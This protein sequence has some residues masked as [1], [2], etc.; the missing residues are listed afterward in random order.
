M[1]SQ[2]KINIPEETS[3]H[4]LSHFESI[5]EIEKDRLIKSG[6]TSIQIEEQLS[7]PGSK[8]FK[9]FATSAQT[10]ID[11]LKTLCPETFTQSVPEQ[12]GRIRMS[13]RLGENI[14]R[15]G[16]IE[17]SSLSISERNTIREEE[18]N[19]VIIKTVR[20]DRI[21]YTNEC[22]LVLWTNNGHYGLCSIFPG[23]LAPPLPT[24]GTEPD[25]YWLTHYFI[26]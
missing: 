4:T 14:G 16:I 25:P 3:F 20:T 22:Q 24:P 6:F 19:G 26:R 10:A 12:D 1:D 21:A 8:F 15:I 18:R 9:S 7:R 13:F 11:R 5:D 2:F 17:D 23:P